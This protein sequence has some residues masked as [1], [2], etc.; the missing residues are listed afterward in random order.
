MPWRR[1]PGALFLWTLMEARGRRGKPE[2]CPGAGCRECLDSRPC[3]K[4]GHSFFPI[5]IEF[6]RKSVPPHL[7]HYFDFHDGNRNG[8]CEG[9]TL[10][11][12]RARSV[13]VCLESRSAHTS[14]TYT[15]MTHIREPEHAYAD[16][17]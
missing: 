11:F 15:P 5:S 7:V 13:F 17:S 6:F 12:G 9:G 3:R 10:P 8:F 14:L 4:V 1:R 16:R 2:W